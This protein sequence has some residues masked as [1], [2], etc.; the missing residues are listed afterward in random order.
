MRDGSTKAE[1]RK[2]WWW[3]GSDG[4]MWRMER[5]VEE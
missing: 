2:G 5:V 4:C 1:S 3:G